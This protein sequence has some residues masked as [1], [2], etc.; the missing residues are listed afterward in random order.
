MNLTPKRFASKPYASQCN[1]CRNLSENKLK[2]GRE[3]LYE[4]HTEF[5]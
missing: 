3:Y 4:Y 5:L 1:V 2:L